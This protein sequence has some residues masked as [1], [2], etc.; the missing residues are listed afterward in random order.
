MN[1]S[2]N[3]NFNSKNDEYNLDFLK[4]N[5]SKN[6]PVNNN[7]MNYN[8]NFDM[9]K[10][11]NKSNDTIIKSNKNDPFSDFNLTNNK[12]S[13]DKKNIFDGLLKY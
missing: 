7:E 3:V 1:K 10:T 9:S 2:N 6:N 5:N 11:A 8:F 12:N 4:G 13:N